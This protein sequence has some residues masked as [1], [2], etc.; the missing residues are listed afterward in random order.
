MA[1]HT[2]EYEREVREE[3]FPWGL[4]VVLVLVIVGGIGFWLGS[5]SVAPV[6]VP[7]A[8]PVAPAPVPVTPVYP[9]Y[10]PHGGG[11]PLFPLFF[12]LIFLAVIFKFVRHAAWGGSQRGGWA[13]SGPGGGG[14]WNYGGSRGRHGHGHGSH[15]H[16]WDTDEQS[17]QSVT[18]TDAGEAAEEGPRGASRASGGPRGAW[19]QGGSK[20]RDF[21]N[22]REVPP[23][24]DEMF[25]RWHS[26]MHAETKSSPDVESA[27]NETNDAGSLT[28]PA[29]ES[30][31]DQST[32]QHDDP[33][34]DRPA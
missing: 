10:A 25:Q 29:K 7:V 3:R 22:S 15:G 16:G 30:P 34:T 5:S 13:A 1:A 18:D 28:L 31:A 24:V 33:P 32:D 19:T 8:A 20:A 14:P 27:S 23:M 4:G 21:W 9:T 11:F 6:V 2:E 26:R 17:G 12:G